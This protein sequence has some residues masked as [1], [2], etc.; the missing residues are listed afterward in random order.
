MKKAVMVPIKKTADGPELH[1]NPNH[2]FMRGIMEFDDYNYASI[3]DYVLLTEPE[4]AKKE[5]IIKERKSLF[6]L[7]VN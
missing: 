2:P 6:S 7:G 1:E 3:N 5:A 4:Q